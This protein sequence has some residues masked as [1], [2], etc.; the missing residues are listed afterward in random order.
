MITIKEIII[1]A[2]NYGLKNARFIPEDTSN[3][4]IE[5]RNGETFFH[6]VCVEDEKISDISQE[7]IDRIDEENAYFL[8]EVF[9]KFNEMEK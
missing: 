2:K 4:G 7:E 6:H 3:C 1:L 9:E 8:P 5:I